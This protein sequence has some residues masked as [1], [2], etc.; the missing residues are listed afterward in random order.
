MVSHIECL[1]PIICS[2]T[3]FTTDDTLNLMNLIPD[4]LKVSMNELRILDVELGR[5]EWNVT[6]HC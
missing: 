4:N 3:Y 1:Y 2:V 5:G 6:T